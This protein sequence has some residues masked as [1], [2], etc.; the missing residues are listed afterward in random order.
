MTIELANLDA[1]LVEQRSERA[2]EWSH[3]RFFEYFVFEQLLKNSGAS[4]EDLV[5]AIVDGGNDCGVDAMICLINDIPAAQY[6]D[7]TT[8]VPNGCKVDLVI[9]Q[10]KTSSSFQERPL[11]EMAV[12]LPKL[13]DP[14]RAD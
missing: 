4:T 2:P 12:R 1:L 5:D 3:D 6:Y 11:L 10:G 13:L 14:Q 8:D 7:L 9:L